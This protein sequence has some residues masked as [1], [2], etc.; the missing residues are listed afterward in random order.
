VRRIGVVALA[1]LVAAACA[2]SSAAP[3]DALVVPLEGQVLLVTGDDQA[4]LDGETDVEGG[5]LVVTGPDGRALLDLGPVGT[6]EIG[7]ESRIRVDRRPEL[8]EG[9]VLARG[10]DPGLVVRAGDAEIAAED[11]RG[12]VF[13]V[14]RAFT[15]VVAVYRGAAEILGSGVEPIPALRQVDVVSGETIPQG[16]RPLEV[17][18]DQ[19]WDIL[20][21]GPAID[22]GIKLDEFQ[23]GLAR[24]LSS[25]DPSEAVVAA[26]AGVVRK[27]LVLELIERGVSGDETIMASEVSWYA[28]QRAESPLPSVLDEV[29]DFRGEGAHWI[30]VAA[31][32]RLGETG[33]LQDLQRMAQTLDLHVLQEP[34]GSTSEGGTSEGDTGGGGGQ[35]GG[36]TGAVSASGS[37]TGGGDTTGESGGSSGSE[38]SSGSGGATSGTGGG[39]GTSSEDSCSGTVDCLIDGVTGGLGGVLGG[40]GGGGSGSG[41]GGLLP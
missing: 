16:P 11:A 37:G 20:Y 10:A 3:D 36:S 18:V 40:G 17:D 12:A 1:G 38:T 29:L 6:V 8:M 13:R 32:W 34:S 4:L 39:G 33:V 26:L 14:D 9:S 22:V 19:P 27:P 30:V 15:V 5:D 35:N 31:R 24:Q 28:A 41:G 23:R 21:L 25:G 2:R 7:P